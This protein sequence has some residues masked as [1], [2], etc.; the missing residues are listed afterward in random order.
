M[1]RIYADNAATS[2]PKPEG[3]LAAMRDYAER[4]GASAGRGGYREAVEAGELLGQCRRDV[5]RLL[6]AEGPD[7]ICFGLNCTD[8][9]NLAIHGAVRAGDHVVTTAMEHNSVLRPLKALE[10]DG[11]RVTYVAPLQNGTGRVS[12]AAIVAAIR[13]ETR[14]IAVQHASNVTG[15]IQPIAEVGAAARQHDILFLVDAAQTAGHVPLDVQAA[16]IDLLAISGHKG[17]LGPLGTGALY[18]RPGVEQRVRPLKQG[19]TGSVSE[20]PHHPDFMPDRYES[21]SHNA[22]GIAGLAASVRW[23]LDR[24]VDSLWRHDQAL[25]ARFLDGLRG[26]AG[27]TLHGPTEPTDRVAVFSVSV[28][29]VEPAELSAVLE[30]EFGLLTR[31]GLHCAP[32]AHE[33]LAT[34][35]AGGTTRLSFGPFTTEADVDHCITALYAI[36]T[37]TGVKPAS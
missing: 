20:D 36:A 28:D 10:A 2:F 27:V 19:G 35:D 18:A 34:R 37:P 24:G 33:A 17:L 26:A 12:A 9:L 8:M 1:K 31:S 5:A 6:N 29:G 3:V 7:H 4:L 25:S 15:V 21:G 30:S 23:I 11:V 14:L 13:P 22:I 32:L 16:N